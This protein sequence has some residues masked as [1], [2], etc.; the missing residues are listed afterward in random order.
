[1][2]VRYI[3]CF[4]LRILGDRGDTLFACVHLMVK[5]TTT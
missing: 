3:D 2:D 1:M 4:L 5:V